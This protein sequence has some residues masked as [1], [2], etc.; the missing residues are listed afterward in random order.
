[1]EN[2]PGLEL[3]DRAILLRTRLLAI[4]CVALVVANLFMGF[5]LW[6]LTVRFDVPIHVSCSGGGYTPASPPGSIALHSR[7]VATGELVDGLPEVRV[8]FR[9]YA[10]AS[11]SG[12]VVRYRE[13]DGVWNQAP[14][15]EE[16][17][18]EFSATLCA[19]PEA[20]LEY[21][22]LEMVRGQAVAGTDVQQVPVKH[23]VGSP[24]VWYYYQQYTDSQYITFYFESSNSPVEKWRVETI[25]VDAVY[26]KTTE[27]YTLSDCFECRLRH[28]DL[29]LLRVA[30]VYADGYRVEAEIRYPWPDAGPESVL[31]T[32]NP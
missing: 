15:S 14:A 4:L 9:A 2:L 26:P 13:K 24:D 11:G 3:K 1:M 6:R 10:R 31:F 17:P 18:L 20:I 12:F 21:Q 30:A 27:S 32:R 22:A 25:F 7:P 19:A 29:Q 5:W 8:G 16:A 23:L 28:Q